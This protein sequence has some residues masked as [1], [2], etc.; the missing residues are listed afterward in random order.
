MEGFKIRYHH[1]RKRKMSKITKNKKKLQEL[2]AGF[3][4]PVSGREALVKLQRNL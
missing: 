2:L 1:E 3:E 4:Q